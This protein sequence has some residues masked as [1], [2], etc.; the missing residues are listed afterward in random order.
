MIR[1]L[2][3]LKAERQFFTQK[4]NP[5]IR[6]IYYAC[7]FQ[8]ISGPLATVF[9][10]A[11]IWRLSG[12]LFNVGLYVAGK[13][14]LLPLGFWVTGMLLKKFHIKDV[15]ALGAVAAGVGY[16][17]V[18]VFNV[19]STLIALL[20]GCFGGF[21]SGIY[22]G[23][24]NY[25]Q[26]QETVKEERQYFFGLIYSSAYLSSIIVPFLAGWFIVLGA[27][28]NWF[29]Q[30][31]AYWILFGISLVLMIIGGAIISRSNF[32]TP[33]PQAITRF[34]RTKFW[35][36]RRILKLG[37]GVTSTLNFLTTLLILITLG[38]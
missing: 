2:N 18:A 29:S 25:L 11:F 15:F 14:L 33:A 12:S 1:I 20:Y 5:N 30:T 36:K 34:G 6:K 38:N 37:Q 10:G 35:T 16:A 17:G 24:R 7:V 21:C 4:L 8:M 22:W 19:E 26:L 23:A 31:Q 32:G 27:Y 9:T 13:S 28:F 3:K